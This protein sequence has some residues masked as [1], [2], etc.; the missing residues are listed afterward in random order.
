MIPKYTGPPIP[1]EV[2]IE[3]GV[4]I[5]T[6]A[7]EKGV[8][9]RLLGALAIRI[10]SAEF[11]HLHT[12]LGRLGEGVQNFSDLDFVA[13]G[14]QRKQ[15]AELLE[16][17]LKYIPNP[18]LNLFFG[19]VRR[20]YYHP[21][22]KY[23]VDVFFDKLEFSHT[24]YFGSSPKDGRLHLDF[25]T[26][27]LADLMLEKLQIHQINEKDI[28]D[29]IVLIRAH[30][31][32]ETD[33]KEIINIKYVS[34]LLADDWGFWYDAKINLSKVLKFAEIYCNEN[35]LGK[36]DYEIVRS[37]V[38]KII[39]RLDEV[40]KTKRWMKRAKVGTKKVWWNEIEEV[41]R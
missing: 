26:I 7:E 2:F 3:D 23:H 10:H 21:E 8:Y 37:K 12:Q 15:V 36:E 16:K 9:L 19:K 4:N 22:G 30:E 13:Y 38:E 40:P 20:I 1:D 11:A 31:L 6:K 27:P 24:I 28:K 18:Q 29:L 5:A 25:P 41:S 33:E 14:K 32:G 39:N 35:K 34:E 17:E